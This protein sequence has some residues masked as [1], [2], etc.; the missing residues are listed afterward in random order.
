MSVFKGVDLFGSG[1]HRFRV[2]PVGQVLRERS[3][4]FGSPSEHGRI[5]VGPLDL[6]VVVEGRLVGASDAAVWTQ[7]DAIQTQLDAFTPAGTLENGRGRVWEGMYFV[8]FAMSGGFD[9]GRV[10][11]VGYEAMFRTLRLDG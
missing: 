7:I 5:P 9:R 2:E 3:F 8:G 4:F 10:V 6:E 11:S 1:P